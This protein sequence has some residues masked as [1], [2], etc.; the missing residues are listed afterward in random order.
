MTG[1]LNDVLIKIHTWYRADDR[2]VKAVERAAEYLWTTQWVPSAKAFQYVG[3]RCVNSTGLDVG[4]RQPAAD[5]NG[6]IVNTY[7]WLYR[8]TGNVAFRSR[9]DAVFEG[10]VLGTYL[11]GEKQ[12]N[13]QYSVSWR[14]LAYRKG[15]P[16]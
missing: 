11:D 13:Q 10:G 7:A 12:F 5:V 14:Y 6:L 15:P 2:L 3:G 8:Q 1:M 4:D 9:A 16:S